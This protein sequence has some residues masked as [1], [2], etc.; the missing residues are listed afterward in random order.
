MGAGAS[1][2]IDTLNLTESALIEALV[3]VSQG[4][5]MVP[6]TSLDLGRTATQAMPEP[7]SLRNLS[8]REREVLCHLA[9]GED[10]LKIAAMLGISERTVKAH[11]SNLYRKLGQENRTQMALF[12]QQLGLKPMH[13]A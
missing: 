7:E 8:L 1:A 2:Y 9:A 12:A 11:V 5:R 4:R 10:N 3:M 13:R 6:L